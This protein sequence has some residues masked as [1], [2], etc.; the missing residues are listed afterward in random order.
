MRFL[1]KYL[2]LSCA[3]IF[4]SG[5]LTLPYIWKIDSFQ[6][7]GGRELIVVMERHGLREQCYDYIW[8]H[9]YKFYSE[10]YYAFKI[11]I[12]KGRFRYLNITVYKT[13]LS[14]EDILNYDFS[15]VESLES[16]FFLCRDLDLHQLRIKVLK[17]EVGEV[18]FDSIEHRRT[19]GTITAGTILEGRLV[20]E[21]EGLFTFT[22]YLAFTRNPGGDSYLFRVVDGR[23]IME[24]W[25]SASYQKV[26][27]DLLSYYQK[28]FQDFPP[29]YSVSSL[30]YLHSLISRFR[31][32]FLKIFDFSEFKESFVL[33]FP[34][35][36]RYRY[37]FTGVISLNYIFWSFLVAILPTSYLLP[38]YILIL[39]I[40]SLYLIINFKTH[41][42]WIKRSPLYFLGI[43]GFIALVF[44]VVITITS[45]RSL[46]YSTLGSLFFNYTPFLALI[47]MFLWL[48]VYFFFPDV[49]V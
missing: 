30:V 45:I 33:T 42:Y 19:D 17:G 23:I 10:L 4:I 28:A 32:H 2:T 41:S 25:I 16:G 5:I 22:R 48:L 46:F 1:K 20:K 7:M 37:A 21:G 47:L 18:K 26:Y 44:A 11:D 38:V 13:G 12:G 35:E 34:R 24:G 39:L 9:C 14:L 3:L 27:P 6:K 29:D 15:R 40:L 31:H 43:T 49:K 36:C 8:K